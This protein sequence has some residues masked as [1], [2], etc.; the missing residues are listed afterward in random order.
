MGIQWHAFGI[1]R[2]LGCR[3]RHRQNRI[4]SQSRL[5]IRAIQLQHGIV[6]TALVPRIHSQQR[7]TNLAIHGLDG[8]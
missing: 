3:E 5:V 6:Q 1:G 7:I 8:F 2:R 4:G